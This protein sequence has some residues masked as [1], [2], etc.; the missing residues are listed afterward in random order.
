MSAMSFKR[1]PALEDES[2]M[3]IKRC[4]GSGMSP[5]SRRER[6]RTSLGGGNILKSE[7]LEIRESDLEGGGGLEVTRRRGTS[8]TGSLKWGQ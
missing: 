6:G 8:N 3:S 1:R 7:I 5:M 2:T 4:P